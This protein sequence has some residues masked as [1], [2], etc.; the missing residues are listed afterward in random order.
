MNNKDLR[1]LLVAEH[2]SAQF[3]GEAALP[4]HYYRVLRSR[5]VPV[6]LLVH[7]RTRKELSQAFPEDSDRILYIPDTKLHRWLW[8]LGRLLPDR[9][10]YFTTGFLMR[11]LTQVLQRR[12]A[13]R[14]VHDHQIRVVHQ[15][16]PV[17]PKEPSMIFGVGAPVLIGPMNGGMNFPPAF[18]YMQSKYID[19]SVAIGRAMSSLMNWLIPGKR[20]AWALL[21]A[22]ART[23]NALPNGLKA[24]VIELVENG[25]DLSLWKTADAHRPPRDQTTPSGI[26]HF[27]FVGRLVELKGIEF[28]LRAFQQARPNQPM[29]LTIIGDGDDRRRLEDMAKEL[30]IH[31]HQHHET[32]GVYFAGWMD[33]KTCAA[34]LNAADAM[35]LPSLHECGGAVVLEAMAMGLPVIATDWGGP[36]DYLDDDCGIL[37]APTSRDAFVNALAEALCRLAASPQLRAQLG[38]AGRKK[39]STTFDWNVKVDQMIALYERAIQEQEV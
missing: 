33:Q 34:Q 39:A 30:D 4:L 35:V 3:G 6:W 12:I 7:E 25:V 36:A 16:I 32:G 15:P 9:I 26:T 37:V 27:V 21:V 1:V 22:N 14:L 29:T 13:R 24:Q 5:G 38:D 20:L 8:R 2:A 28:L 31:A 23:R 10:S 17:S 11:L 18:R 19:S